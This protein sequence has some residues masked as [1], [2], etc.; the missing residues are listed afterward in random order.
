MRTY[1]IPAITLEENR[2]HGD[3]RLST[4]HFRVT[5]DRH[6]IKT[7]IG[8]FRRDADG[9]GDGAV[10]VGDGKIPEVRS[11]TSEVL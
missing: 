6:I 5:S 8:I 11:L 10:G 7:I 4:T 9:V 3:L 2:S 1:A